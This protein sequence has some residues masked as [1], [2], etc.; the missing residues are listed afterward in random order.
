LSQNRVQRNRGA[1]ELLRQ[2]ADALQVFAAHEA[3]RGARDAAQFVAVV[4]FQN[5][6]TIP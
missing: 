3:L 1:G 4:T 5:N 6:F 2:R